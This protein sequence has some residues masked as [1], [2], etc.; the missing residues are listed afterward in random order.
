MH[1]WAFVH[2]EWLPKPINMTR[3][4]AQALLWGNP[5]P[6]FLTHPAPLRP[7]QSPHIP[8][9][10]TDAPRLHPGCPL[11]LESLLDSAHTSRCTRHS[12]LIFLNYSWHTILPFT[13]KSSLSAAEALVQWLLT[14]LHPFI[15]ALITLPFK[16]YGHI[17]IFYMCSSL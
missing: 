4:A 14:F 13:L 11:S 12:P 10:L 16:L 8:N 3:T 17:F 7:P 6:R 5:Q 1:N 15:L 9:T 2:K